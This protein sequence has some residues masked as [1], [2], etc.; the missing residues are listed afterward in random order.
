MREIAARSPSS[1]RL[2]V[3]ILLT[4]LML[5]IPQAAKAHHLQDSMQIVA[6]RGDVQHYQEN[7]LAAIGSAISKGAHWVEIDIVMNLDSG[8]LIV[9]HDVT[10]GYNQHSIATSPWWVLE[11]WC[12][13][14]LLDEVFDEFP[15]AKNWI[16]DV[17]PTGDTAPVIGDAVRQA[18]HDRGLQNDVW[19]TSA[20]Q[21]ILDP[22]LTVLFDVKDNSPI[23][24][25][26]GKCPD[27]YSCNTGSVTN[28]INTASAW[29]FDAV[30]IHIAQASASTVAHAATLGVTYSVW[31]WHSGDWPLGIEH[32]KESHHDLAYQYGA[33]MFFTDFLDHSLETL[34]SKGHGGNDPHHDPNCDPLTAK[35]ECY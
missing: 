24:T 29:G 12:H 28:W 16:I 11:A 34:G 17:K 7:S 4:T 5:V 30:N 9:D 14:L 18:I 6:H 21:S 22:A 23:K 35:R 10:C 19:V 3:A 1:L 32:Q 27:V 2:P 25:M 26:W 15:T 31:T 8:N 13:P 20:A 33:D